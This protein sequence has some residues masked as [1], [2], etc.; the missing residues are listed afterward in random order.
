VN[1]GRRIVD[2]NICEGIREPVRRSETLAWIMLISPLQ[3]MPTNRSNAQC[4]SNRSREGMSFDLIDD[5]E[6]LIHLVSDVLLRHKRRCHPEEYMAGE[7][8]TDA[9]MNADPNAPLERRKP[10]AG[11][12]SRRGRKRSASGDPAADLRDPQRLRQ[13]SRHLGEYNMEE[14]SRLP[15]GMPL[16]AAGG[17]MDTRSL[18]YPYGMPG[19]LNGL[20]N[21]PSGFGNGNPWDLGYNRLNT[22]QNLGYHVSATG[23]YDPASSTSLADY[24]RLTQGHVDNGELGMSNQLG[25]AA[26]QT[27]SPEDNI[28]QLDPRLSMSYEGD[29][30]NYGDVPSQRGSLAMYGNDSKGISIHPSQ[31]PGE[32]RYPGRNNEH[33]Y[34]RSSD[35][36]FNA[37]NLP[38]PNQ[39]SDASH[40]SRSGGDARN[41]SELSPHGIEEA[42]ALLSMAYGNVSALRSGSLSLNNEMIDS[43]LQ[44]VGAAYNAMPETETSATQGNSLPEAIPRLEEIAARVSA[45]ANASQQNDNSADGLP[46]RNIVTYTALL[47]PSSVNRNGFPGD[48]PFG[49]NMSTGLTP[50]ANSENFVSRREDPSYV[51]WLTIFVFRTPFHIPSGPERVRLSI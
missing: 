25:N 49:M 15:Y 33:S 27:T 7:G 32:H 9:A 8:A 51:V 18:N 14:S 50:L 22:D 4:A 17:P 29:R 37:G 39:L 28:A 45:I 41:D 12:S 44:S 46:G 21:G 30:M 16:D 42:A 20:G 13:D 1:A 31:A 47:N 35:P 2:S 34:E 43:S 10:Q 3:T 40:Q 48:L 6:V 11:G 36:R 38:L 26:A 24:Q 19:L 23:Q 5:N